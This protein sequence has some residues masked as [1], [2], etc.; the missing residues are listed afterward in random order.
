M[1]LSVPGARDQAR[2]FP[3]SLLLGGLNGLLAI[4]LQAGEMQLSLYY[5]QRGPKEGLPPHSQ[6]LCS[7]CP[8]AEPELMPLRGN[9]ALFSL[10]MVR[11]QA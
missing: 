3:Q 8:R 4:A 6:D 7:Y 10:S 2:G 11:A 5:G 9:S 1:W